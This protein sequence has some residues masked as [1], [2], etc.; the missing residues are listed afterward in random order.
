VKRPTVLL[1]CALVSTPAL[2]Q[3]KT[4]ERQT[5]PAPKA[6]AITLPCDPLN[7]LPGCVSAA[8]VT[9]DVS[10]S[11]DLWAKIVNASIADLTYAQALAKAA[12][13]V[14]SSLR[15]VCYGAILTANQQA[16]GSNVL[17]ADG[18][19]PL[20]KPNP[21]VITTLEQGAEVLDELQSTAP[22]MVA[23]AP[24]ANAAKQDV[25]TFVS[26]V[27]AGVAVKAATAGVLP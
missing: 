1:L 9:S 12:N 6:S 5:A 21:A 24:A 15:A 3:S 26:T 23:C 19:T 4:P 22:V 14:G 18:K 16:N 13:T 8:G 11:G 7:L 17:A 20:T 27:L 2:A 10:N 25:L